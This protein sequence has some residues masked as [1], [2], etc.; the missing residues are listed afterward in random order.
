MGNSSE[1]ALFFFLSSCRNQPHGARTDV[2]PTVFCGD[3]SRPLDE[4]VGLRLHLFDEDFLFPAHRGMALSPL[5]NSF[6][7]TFP[8][9]PPSRGGFLFFLPR[10]RP[11]RPPPLPRP[12]KTLGPNS[13]H[14]PGP[15]WRVRVSSVFFFC[16][17]LRSPGGSLLFLST[18]ELISLF[19][20]S[21][22][23][24][25]PG[26][27]RYTLLCLEHISLT[28]CRSPLA[29]RS[30]QKGT[31]FSPESPAP[32]RCPLSHANPARFLP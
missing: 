6:R 17:I 12:Q 16:Q 2:S 9:F 29:V 25:F 3:S 1:V 32:S 5:S 23:W 4:I 21:V 14:S 13:C 18:A 8:H 11:S 19:I 24:R 22:T 31:V 15:L 27:L 20:L 26:G 10:R 30:R 7:A 28:H